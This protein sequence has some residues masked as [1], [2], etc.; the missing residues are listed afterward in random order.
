MVF[1]ID[2]IFLA[3]AALTATASAIET[4]QAGK[5]ARRAQNEQRNQ[6][7]MQYARERRQTIRNMRMAYA[8]AEQNQANQGVSGGSAQGGLGSIITQGNAQLSF[9]DDQMQSA[10]R[11][12]AFMD[13]AAKHQ[14]MAGM[15]GSVSQLAM[16]G[17]KTGIFDSPPTKATVPKP[18]ASGTYQ[19]QYD[20][21]MGTMPSS[22]F[23]T[24]SG[25]IIKR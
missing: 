21:S 3:V 20:P 23:V 11:S 15:W 5:S 19:G 4:Q 16:M 12:G 7:N 6:Q 1:G 10:N 24:P 17:Y 8:T 9:L 18:S 13:S 14:G 25:S 2:D 22:V